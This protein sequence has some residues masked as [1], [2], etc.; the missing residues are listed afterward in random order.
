MVNGITGYHVRHRLPG[1]ERL[2]E[3]TIKTEDLQ[4][5]MATIYQRGEEITLLEPQRKNLEDF[6]L[7]IV[8]QGKGND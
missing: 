6:F 8:N 2:K 3:T 5:F 7:G 1:E 4:E